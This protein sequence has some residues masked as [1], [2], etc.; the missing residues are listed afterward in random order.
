MPNGNPCM[1]LL[2]PPLPPSAPAS[3]CEKLDSANVCAFELAAF[4]CIDNFTINLA[5]GHLE[6]S[7]LCPT[8]LQRASQP[9]AY[10]F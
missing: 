1:P 9:N 6:F 8:Q 7:I 10:I 4:Q 3:R 5:I 2:G